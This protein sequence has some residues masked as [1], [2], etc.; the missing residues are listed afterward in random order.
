MK[1][2]I[3]LSLSLTGEYAPMGRQAEAAMRLFV[4]D[5]NAS[6]ALRVGGERCELALDCHDDASDPSRCSE[7]YRALCTTSGF[8]PP[9][10]RAPQRPGDARDA[11][12]DSAKALAELGWAPSTTLADGIAATYQYFERLAPGY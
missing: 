1:I 10:E 9:I 6:S 3:G 12:F 11:Q 2:T 4:A 8:E 5:A 7:I